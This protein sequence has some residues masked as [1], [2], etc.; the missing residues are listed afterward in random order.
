VRDLMRTLGASGATVLVSSHILS[1]IQQ[2]CDSVSIVSRG[3]HVMTGPVSEVIASRDN[4]DVRVRVSDLE[5]AA[6]ILE[7]SGLPVKR[8]DDHLIVSDIADPSWITQ[9]LSRRRLFVS[10]LTPVPPDLES[11]FLELTGTMPIPGQRLQVGE[12]RPRSGV[13]AADPVAV[14]AVVGAPADELSN[15]DADGSD[16]R[17]GAGA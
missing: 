16:D 7:S 13:P 1:E 3:R 17:T 2:V 10:E 14:P 12:A 11:I 9:T 8:E 4:H 5:E 6:S 15:G